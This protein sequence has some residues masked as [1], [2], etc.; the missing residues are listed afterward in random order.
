MT[1]RGPVDVAAGPWL[2][3]T[4]GGNGLSV[5]P[6]NGDGTFGN[7]LGAG[8]GVNNVLIAGDF[9]GD[10]HPDI[11]FAGADAFGVLLFVCE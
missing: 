11:A 2:G 9:N 6:G 8:S 10:G 3:A 1:T 7:A 4:F 5:L